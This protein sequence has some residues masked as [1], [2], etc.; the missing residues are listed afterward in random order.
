MYYLK[1]ASEHEMQKALSTIGLWS[2]SGLDGQGEA[3]G[4]YVLAGPCGHLDIIGSHHTPL[5]NDL[6]H[7]LNHQDGSPQMIVVPNVFL[8]NLVWDGPLTAE[9]MALAIEAPSTPSRHFS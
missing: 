2:D 4:G 9:V 5:L 6:G 3:V 8:A 1:A 7:I